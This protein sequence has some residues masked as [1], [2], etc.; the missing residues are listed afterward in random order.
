MTTPQPTETGAA[1]TLV[2]C[3]GNGTRY[4][5]VYG[6]DFVALPDFGVAATCTPFPAEHTYLQ[7]KLNLRNEEDAKHV[8]EALRTAGGG[9]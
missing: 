6:R 1:K 4:F 7:T 5:I 9:Q 2:V 8:F 3:P